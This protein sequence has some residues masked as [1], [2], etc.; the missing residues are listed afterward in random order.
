MICGIRKLLLF[1]TGYENFPVGTFFKNII[2][3]GDGETG[4]LLPE[5]L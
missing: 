4:E 5:R 2:Y 3:L 1:P